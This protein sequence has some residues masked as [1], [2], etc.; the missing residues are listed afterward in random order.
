MRR[1]RLP[2]GFISVVNTPGG[3]ASRNVRRPNLIAGASPYLNNDRNVI[4]PAAFS[5]P[6]PARSAISSATHCADQSSRSIA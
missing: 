1:I 5:I 2:L 6:L 3:G 4:N